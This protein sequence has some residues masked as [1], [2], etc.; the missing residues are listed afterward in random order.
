MCVQ[1]SSSRRFKEWNIDCKVYIG[2]LSETAS[3]QDVEG[4]LQKYGKLKN[5]WV[6]RKPPGFAFVEYEDPR[7]ADDAVRAL[8]GTRICG[9]RVRVE[10]SH[11]RS[12]RNP[13]MMRRGYS[14]RD[15]GRDD[16]R[17]Y[18]NGGERSRG[19]E[20]EERGRGRHSPVRRGR[21]RTRSRT[22][23]PKRS[24]YS[25]SKSRSYSRSRS[26]RGR[27]ISPR[28]PPPRSPRSPPPRSPSRSP[29]SRGSPMLEKSP[30][31]I[32]KNGHRGRHSETRSRS[33]TPDD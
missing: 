1:M 14:S 33:I 26:P 19:R 18:P 22:P 7:D 5:V 9:S 10:K 17:Y 31:Y 12:K 16:G 27:S 24:R 23:P 15:N 4:V 3:K 2:N 20:R 8:D 25:K 11:G 6:A 32:S 21:S 28:S 13:P 30:R 29:D